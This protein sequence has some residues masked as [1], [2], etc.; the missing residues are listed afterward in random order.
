MEKGRNKEIW[1]QRLDS[2]NARQEWLEV[3][4]R[5]LRPAA[6]ISK[7]A[8]DDGDDDDQTVYDK[9]CFDVLGLFLGAFQLLLKD[10][11]F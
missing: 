6:H 11:H 9:R 3:H 4:G 5:G 10:Q 7:A 2:R 1:G 8:D